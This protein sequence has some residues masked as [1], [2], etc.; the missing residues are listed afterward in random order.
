MKLPL[1]KAQAYGAKIVAELSPYCSRIEL[2]GSIRRK[3]PECHDIDIVCIPTDVP[4]LK[5]RTL[6]N[7]TELCCGEQVFRVETSI[8]IQID[9]YFAHAGKN[10]LFRPMPSN[11]GTLRVCRTGSK[12]HNIKLCNAAAKLGLKWDPHHG[13]FDAGGECVAAA[14][15]E[16]VFEALKMDYIAPE[17]REVSA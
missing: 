7:A 15:E 5:R 3:R 2:A 14:K 13:V 6:Q 12:E 8:G 4:G 17:K 1:A 16:E 10:D 11:G 9:I